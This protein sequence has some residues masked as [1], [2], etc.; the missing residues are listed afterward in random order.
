MDDSEYDKISNDSMK[1]LVNDLDDSF[2]ECLQSYKNYAAYA[3]DDNLTAYST[4]WD[5]MMNAHKMA[6]DTFHD[7]LEPDLKQNGE[8]EQIN[9]IREEIK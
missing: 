2:D 3:S 5:K 8:F 1:K 4:K 7:T 6:I 9:R